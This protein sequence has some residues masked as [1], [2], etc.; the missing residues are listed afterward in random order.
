MH[1]SVTDVLVP[2]LTI[3]TCDLSGLGLSAHYF[4]AISRFAWRM[5]QRES[6]GSSI[7]LRPVYLLCWFFR[8]IAPFL[9]SR[10]VD[11]V[12]FPAPHR[13]LRYV[14]FVWLLVCHRI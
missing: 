4:Q 11:V 14:L 7:W 10:C 1:F 13:Y 3:W 2:L 6:M 8:S 9:R 5:E 12:Y